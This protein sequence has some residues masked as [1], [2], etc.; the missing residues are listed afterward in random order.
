MD[1][2]PKV[3]ES[4]LWEHRHHPLSQ[5]KE[6]PRRSLTSV[7]MV[8]YCTRRPHP[9]GSIHMVNLYIYYDDFPTE[10]KSSVLRKRYFYEHI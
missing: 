6:A 9:R 3:I 10:Q 2:L 1:F 5:L 7:T 8:V 4:C